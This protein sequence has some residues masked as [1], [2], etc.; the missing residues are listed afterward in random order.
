[1]GKAAEAADALE[2]AFFRAAPQTKS[3]RM[4]EDAWRQALERFHDEA[5]QIRQRYSLGFIARARA[6]YLL[7][8]RLIA[9]GIQADTVRKVIFSLVVGSFI[10]TK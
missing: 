5:K 10:S 2:K 9:A 6:A 3:K 7:Q 4:S 1:V 8:Q